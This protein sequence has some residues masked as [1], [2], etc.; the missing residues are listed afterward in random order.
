[1]AISGSNYLQQRIFCYNRFSEKI[2]MS[3]EKANLAT[4][5]NSGKPDKLK[6]E[7]LPKHYKPDESPAAKAFMKAVRM[8]RKRFYPELSEKTKIVLR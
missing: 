8:T 1:M 4:K 6:Y 2:E 7:Y 5:G 3:E